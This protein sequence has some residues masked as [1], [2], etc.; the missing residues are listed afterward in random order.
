MIGR[1]GN[2]LHR[3]KEFGKIDISKT[4]QVGKNKEVKATFSGK[5]IWLKLTMPQVSLEEI[6]LEMKQDVVT[7]CS[8]DRENRICKVIRG[9]VFTMWE[10]NSRQ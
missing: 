2:I 7:L 6:K 3:P 8:A 5:S 1:F 4:S 10:T 9:N